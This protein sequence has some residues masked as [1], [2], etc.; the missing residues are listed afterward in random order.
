MSNK[1]IREAVIEVLRRANKPLSPKEVYE[2][3]VNSDLYTFNAKSPESLVS[4]E[5]RRH[6]EGIDL[7]TSK[8]E[9]LFK[10]IN[11]KYTLIIG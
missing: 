8:P 9:K 5:L 11:G 2:E 3:I 1:T 10:L 4:G 6:C 7:K